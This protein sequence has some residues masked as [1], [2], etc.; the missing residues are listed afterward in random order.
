MGA[1][2]GFWASMWFTFYQHIEP[3]PQQ[4]LYVC[5]FMEFLHVRIPD[6]KNS[7]KNKLNLHFI[8]K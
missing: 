3:T 2:F 1:T 8:Q 4:I 5:N 7:E 6:I